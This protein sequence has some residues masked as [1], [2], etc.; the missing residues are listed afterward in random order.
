MKKVVKVSIGNLAFTVEEDG[1]LLIKGYLKEIQDH[2]ESNENG[3]EIVEGIEERMAELFL[4]KCPAN[5]VVTS[6]VIK[7]V[8]AILGR[9]EAIDEEQGDIRSTPSGSSY[10]RVPKK[11]FRNTDNKILGGVCSGLGAYSSLDVSLVRIIFVVLLIGFS[12]FG[13]FRIGGFSFML[14]AYIIMWIVI[15]EARTVEQ[16]CAMFGE[17]MD[18]SHI[19]QKM[20]R[21]MRKAGR[22]IQRAANENSEIVSGF[23]RLLAVIISVILIII[24]VSGIAT[25]SFLLLGIEVFKGV[26]P[27]DLIDYVYL[28]VQNPIYLKIAICSFFMLPFLGMLYGGIQLLF[29]FKTSRI[30]PGLIILLLW[31][32]SL[33]A[34]I[35][36]SVKSTR[37]YWNQAKNS[38]EIALNQEVD[39]IYVRFVANKTMPKERVVLYGGYSDFFICWMDND[40]NN[41]KNNELVIF[42]DLRIVR[43]SPKEE[44]TLSYRTYAHAHNY[45]D[46]LLKAERE[47]PSIQIEDSVITISPAYYNK[48]NK[49]SGVLQKIS[50][51]VPEKVVIIVKEPIE[52][53]FDK[54]TTKDWMMS[55]Y[56]NKYYNRRFNNWERRFEKRF[57]RFGERLEEKFNKFEDSLDSNDF[58]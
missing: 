10:A 57:D 28:G 20:E 6:S 11:L 17:P 39:T 15:P 49:W 12:F 4:E 16:R 40:K 24:A 38:G 1:F 45:S 34:M 31:I 21:N 58:D 52:H 51:N 36:F 54:I 47:V 19:H 27:I 29:G 48:E 33:L 56:N 25:F 8:I 23:G 41:D 55:N 9:P 42:P 26:I 43:Q 46:A 18:F 7:D 44:R 2:Y 37:P 35:F 13:M 30:R 53:N 32:V 3:R 22:G 5:S 14:V 50:L